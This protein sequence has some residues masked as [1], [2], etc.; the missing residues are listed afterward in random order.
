VL[1]LNHR[2]IFSNH[3]DAQFASLNFS[4]IL[5]LMGFNIT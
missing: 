2:F 5:S 4:A 3:P 1:S